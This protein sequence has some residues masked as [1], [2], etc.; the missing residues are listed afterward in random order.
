MNQTVGDEGEVE[1]ISTFFA[2]EMGMLRELGIKAV[3]GSG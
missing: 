2:S 1:E 3:S